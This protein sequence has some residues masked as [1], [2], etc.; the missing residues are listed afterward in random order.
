M[1]DERKMDQNA[2]EGCPSSERLFALLH[3]P[4][5]LTREER[6]QIERHV[7]ECSL[8]AEE[9]A[10]LKKDLERCNTFEPDVRDLESIAAELR[11]PHWRPSIPDRLYDL[12]KRYPCPSSRVY[13]RSKVQAWL[14]RLRRM[15]QKVSDFFDLSHIG[16][17]ELSPVVVR[18]G[19]RTASLDEEMLVDL[20]LAANQGMDAGDY[21]RAGEL[22]G[23]ISELVSGQTLGRDVRFLAGVAYL[24]SGIVERAL[25]YLRDSIDDESGVEHYWLL[26]GALLEA[27]DLE[28]AFKTLQ[29][30]ESMGGSWG[31]KA[32]RLFEEMYG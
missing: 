2:E 20:V 25:E 23:K 15:G 28:G 30:V 27:G 14:D 22:Y 7:R 5:D 12:T 31:E 19:A 29:M 10:F 13:D 11:S 32:R 1:S 24:R 3:N 17:P 8:C 16:L 9:V 6:E 26:A 21:K 4:E 18:S